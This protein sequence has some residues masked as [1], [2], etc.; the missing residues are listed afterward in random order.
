MSSS[1][2]E[3]I[4]EDSGIMYSE[5]PSYKRLRSEDDDSRKMS[6][7]KK[8]FNPNWLK[9]SMFKDWLLPHKLADKAVCKVCHCVLVAGKSEL[10]KHMATRKHERNMEKLNG[11]PIEQPEDIETYAIIS[12]NEDDYDVGIQSNDYHSTSNY[13]K[14][15]QKHE[16]IQCKAMVSKPAPFW[17][18][19]AVVNGH[20]T[21]LKLSDYN[22]RYLVLFFYPQDFSR[23]CPSE[24]IALSDRV[25]EFRALNTEVVACSVDSYLSHQAWSR[26]LRSDGGIAIPKMPLLSDPTHTISKSYGCY[27]PELGHSLRAHYIIDMR[28]ILR[29]VTINDLPVGR[30][31]GEIL[32]LLEAFQYT[33][34]TETLCPADWKP[35]EPTIS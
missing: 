27:L 12:D 23:I 26:T 34:E 8:S 11:S 6:L 4:D 31:I 13:E 19:T 20:V 29:H 25:S 21:E 1:N 15:D 24:L 2:V 7:T 17:K 35:G 14:M 10:E 32:R 3:L 16:D 33:D 28:G 30:N 5:E 18:A 9:F 22:G